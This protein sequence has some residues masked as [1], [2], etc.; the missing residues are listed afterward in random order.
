MPI[1]PSPTADTNRVSLYV[2][3]E[4]CWGQ[5]PGTAALAPKAYELKM[6]GESL[7]HNK[8]TVVSNVIRTDRMRDSLSEV[9]ASA[10]GELNYELSF[11]DF[12]FLIEGA[13]AA[14]IEYL[15]ERTV[16]APGDISAVSATSLFSVL[17]GAINF[18][19]FVPGADVHVSGYEDTAKNNG[20]FLISAVGA[21]GVSLTVNSERAGSATI[22]D[23]EVP[24][25][26]LFLPTFKTSKLSW[27]DLVVASD[28]TITSATLNFLTDVNLAVG[29]HIRIEGAA[30]PANNKV[31]KIVGISATTLTFAPG[32]ALV[33]AAAATLVLTAARIRNGIER[34]SYLVEKKFG[35]VDKYVAFTGM[36]VGQMSL[37]VESQALV[38]GSFSMQGKEGAGSETSV[39][40]TIIPAGIKDALN[41]TTNV[42]QIEEGGTAVETAIRSVMISIN[43]NLRPKPQIGS[44]SPVDIGLGFVDVTGTLTAYFEDLAMFNKFIN[45]T[46]SQ[47]SFRFTD[48]ESNVLVFTLPRLYFSAGT[49]QAPQGNDDVMLGLEFTAVRSNVDDAVIILDLLQGPIA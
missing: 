22:L 35:D 1:C 15:V 31:V 4:P 40:G 26:P 33:A 43:N 47:L 2:S 6:T 38:T 48:S 28:T 36:R 41:A 37:N 14:N 21:A 20:R 27:T 10:E 49:P 5:A 13:F 17:A 39:L 7:V 16:V 25:D 32:T 8:Q 34:K 18:T 23:D 9:G 19:G 24:T 45:H 3:P 30:N 29:Q 42:G 12:D 11:R 46:S 44:K